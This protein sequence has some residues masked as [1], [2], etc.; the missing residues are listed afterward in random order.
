MPRSAFRVIDRSHMIVHQLRRRDITDERVLA[1]FAE[2]PRETTVLGAALIIGAGLVALNGERRR[3]VASAVAAT[4][5]A[6]AC[7]NR[8]RAGEYD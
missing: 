7:A 5:D 1:A 6:V 2:V 8:G 4:G 3:S